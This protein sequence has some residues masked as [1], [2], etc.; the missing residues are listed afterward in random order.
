VFHVF[1]GPIGL[2]LRTLSF[3]PLAR[4][5]DRLD[6]GIPNAPSVREQ[7]VVVVNAP[8]N[9]MLSYLQ[10]A[11]AARG[12]PRPQ[13]LYWLAS[14]SSEITVE[15]VDAR[16]LR[17]SQADGFLH[18]PEETHYRADAHDLPAGTQLAR[19]GMQ[20]EIETS[21]P[22]QRPHSVLFRFDEP[23]ESPRY[24][25]RA[26]RAG[27]LVPWQPPAAGGSERFPAQPFADIIRREVLP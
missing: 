23:L 25:L 16:S 3:E 10:I 8:F 24:L 4:A 26:Y 13:H 14:S 19:A 18:R 20:I 7:T 15:R 27:E 5:M 17:V 11:R 21:E 1:A 2:P 6:T 22:D 9:I 12:V